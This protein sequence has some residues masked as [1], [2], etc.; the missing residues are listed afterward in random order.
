ME[1]LDKPNEVLSSV[2][3]LAPL[4]LESALQKPVLEERGRQLIGSRFIDFLTEKQGELTSSTDLE[5]I[6]NKKLKSR[7]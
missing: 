7:I 3:A 4:P 6:L 5:N 2:W 1:Q